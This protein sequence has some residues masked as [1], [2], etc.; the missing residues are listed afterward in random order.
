MDEDLPKVSDKSLSDKCMKKFSEQFLSYGFEQLFD[1][2]CKERCVPVDLEYD[3]SKNLITNN[4]LLFYPGIG[5]DFGMKC[6]QKFDFNSVVNFAVFS[7]DGQFVL[8]ALDD[9]TA[10]LCRLNGECVVIFNH[11]EPV[12]S[13][14]F[15]LDGRFILTRTKTS[16]TLCLWGL[17]G[18]FIKI[19]DARE[20]EQIVFPLLFNE[21]EP[22][23]FSKDI[24]VKRVCNQGGQLFRMVALI[25]L[26]KSLPGMTAPN[27][28]CI[29][30]VS[31]D[32]IVS[33]WSLDGQCL[34][35][36]IND[37]ILN[38]KVL[39]PDGEFYLNCPGSSPAI[40]YKFHVDILKAGTGKLVNSLKHLNQVEVATFSPDGRYIVTD[41]SGGIKLWGVNG[42]AF[43][44]YRH[45]WYQDTAVFSP[46]CKNVLIAGG[47]SANLWNVHPLWDSDKYR[48]GQLSLSEL[49]ANLLILKFKNIVKQDSSV[50]SAV[51][52]IL[53]KIEEKEPII[54][55]FYTEFLKN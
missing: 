18:N 22:L 35:A 40:D 23:G 7:P 38:F 28:Q 29:L 1:M 52:A 41:V 51:L 15:S 32:H 48:N 10:R 2:A 31:L 27:N 26:S 45:E 54:K 12:A 19:F 14:M 55:N 11:V 36:F 50:Q 30:I 39:S 13:A 53:N 37:K 8:F 42:Q 6:I 5:E 16:K 20:S 4:C 25:E 33:L 46:D 47:R 34:H 17:S 3:I 9:N 24:Q 49:A 21:T 43:K 44:V